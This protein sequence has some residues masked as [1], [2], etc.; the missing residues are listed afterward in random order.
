M[1]YLKVY[2]ERKKSAK[3]CTESGGDNKE[4]LNRLDLR[5]RLASELKSYQ[6]KWHLSAREVEELTGITRATYW[7]ILEL[8]HKIK[9]R[10][11]QLKKLLKLPAL[12]EQPELVKVIIALLYYPDLIGS[13]WLD[14]DGNLSGLDEKSASFLSGNRR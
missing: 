1:S 14:E 13:L 5:Q 7:S 12:T 9:P 10:E 8:D 6:S 3:G 11:N 4:T 2:Q